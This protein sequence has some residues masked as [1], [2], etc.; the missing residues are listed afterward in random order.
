MWLIGNKQVFKTG[1]KSE[2]SNQSCLYKVI[3]SWKM[4]RDNI[5][6]TGLFEIIFCLISIWMMTLLKTNYMRNLVE[7]RG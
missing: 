2:L 4:F 5:D 1:L 3:K 7:K 6:A